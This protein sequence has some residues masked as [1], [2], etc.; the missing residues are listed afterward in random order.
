L[1]YLGAII[2]GLPA[3]PFLIAASYFFLRSSPRLHRWLRRSPWV[4][5]VLHDWEEH[6][7]VRRS[8]RI[9]ACCLIVTVVTLTL[10]FSGLP[11]WAKILIA[12]LA[13]IGLA[14]VVSLPTVPT[15]TRRE[16]AH[17]ENG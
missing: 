17:Q 14:V 13:A 4:G 12:A 2:P 15:H 7:G 9:T 10:L 6:R 16:A 8:V 3:T 5:R 11:S 1:G